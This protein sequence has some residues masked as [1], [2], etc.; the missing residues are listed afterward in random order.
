MTH[1]WELYRQD[2]EWTKNLSLVL[3]VLN[4]LKR[5]VKNTWYG[6]IFN[7]FLQKIILQW[8]KPSR[9]LLFIKVGLTKTSKGFRSMLLGFNETKTCRII[10]FKKYGPTPASFSFIF[11]LF[12]Q[13][14]QI[15]TTNICDKMSITYMVPGFEPTTFGTWVS[16]HNH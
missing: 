1:P 16:S 13:T 10:F 7:C 8:N 5:Y 15:F 14:L 3:F 2:Y 4:E 12:K 6:K 9:E 11:D